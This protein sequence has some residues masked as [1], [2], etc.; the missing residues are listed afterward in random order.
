MKTSR[1]FQSK[2][3][4]LAP[5]FENANKEM[6]RQRKWSRRDQMGVRTYQ[7]HLG[8]DL[9]Q[10]EPPLGHYYLAAPRSHQYPGQCSPGLWHLK[11]TTLML[12]PFVYQNLHQ[13]DL[14]VWAI[15][16]CC[17]EGKVCSVCWAHMIAQ[18]VASGDPSPCWRGPAKVCFLS[19]LSA[20]F[21]CSI[22]AAVQ[23]EPWINRQIKPFDCPGL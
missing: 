23:S 16:S 20:S 9:S 5:I 17:K 21:S 8:S 10:R 2:G 18:S 14:Y 15:K 13:E 6:E 1:T 11:D 22:A 19:L 12:S 3:C 4:L 7:G